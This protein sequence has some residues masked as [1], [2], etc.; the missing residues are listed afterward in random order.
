MNVEI[1]CERDD[2][3]PHLLEIHRDAFQRPDEAELVAKLR[4][5]PDYDRDYSFVA[6]SDGRL[7]GHLLFTPMEIHYDSALMIRT[8]FALAPISVRREFQRQ[9][10]GTRLI[11]FGLNQIQ[12]NGAPSAIVLGHEHFYPKFGFLPAKTF[13]LRPPFPLKNENSLMALEL[14]LHGLPLDEGEGLLRYL[15]EFGF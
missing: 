8:S 11:G 3:F 4:L 12:K 6:V 13:H 1:R 2:D 7:I 15:P 9:G 10:V 5:N 14:T